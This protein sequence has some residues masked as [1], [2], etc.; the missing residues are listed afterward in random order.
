MAVVPTKRP[1]TKDQLI[2][3]LD[4]SQVQSTMHSHECVHVCVL[5]LLLCMYVAEMY[6]CVKCSEMYMYVHAECT[7]LCIIHSTCTAPSVS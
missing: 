2:P 7:V 4:V 3:L 1:K 6:C 5:Y